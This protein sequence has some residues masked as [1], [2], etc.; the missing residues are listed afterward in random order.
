MALFKV[1]GRTIPDNLPKK[2]GNINSNITSI[3]GNAAGGSG[4]SKAYFAGGATNTNPTQDSQ[5]ISTIYGLDGLTQFT[6][7][8][9]S[10]LSQ[11]RVFSISFLP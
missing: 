4:G 7:T 10:A 3:V 5:L 2:Y 1:K 11:T 9:L 8:A 6:P